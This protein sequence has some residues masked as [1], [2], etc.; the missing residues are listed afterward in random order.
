[1]GNNVNSAGAFYPS[2]A[3]AS[4]VSNPWNGSSTLDSFYYNA[5]S[6][7]T[8]TAGAIAFNRARLG[9][10]TAEVLGGTSSTSSWKVGSGMTGSYS[11]FVNDSKSW[12]N[13]G[14]DYGTSS[15]GA[16]Y[17]NYYIGAS[18]NSDSFRSSLS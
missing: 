15:S 7:G 10:A 11:G 16:F 14:G 13:R 12:F 8:R 4:G 17:L 6:Y 5:Y 9:D 2:S 18:S 1:M 3:V